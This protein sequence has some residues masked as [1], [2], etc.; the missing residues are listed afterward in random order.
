MNLKGPLKIDV[1]LDN[2]LISVAR[3]LKKV[4]TVDTPRQVEN[5]LR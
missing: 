2:F 1:T 5:C 3:R 4:P